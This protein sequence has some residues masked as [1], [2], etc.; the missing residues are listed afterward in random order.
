MLTVEIN[1]GGSYA[2]GRIWSCASPVKRVVRFLGASNLCWSLTYFSP[3]V[4]FV[5]TDVQA[6]QTLPPYSLAR[7]KSS[8]KPFLYHRPHIRQEYPLNLSI[9]LSGGKESKS[10][11][12]SNGEWTGISLALR[13]DSMAYGNMSRILP[14]RLSSG[15]ALQTMMFSGAIGRVGLRSDSALSLACKFHWLGLIVYD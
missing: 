2:E 15:A 12:P 7:L 6:T 10:D 5:K 14:M 1:R 11:F 13:L 4:N 3:K 8:W 9:L